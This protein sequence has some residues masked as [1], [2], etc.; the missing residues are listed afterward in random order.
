MWGGIC[1]RAGLCKDWEGLGWEGLGWVAV[2]SF[3]VARA[4]RRGAGRAAR[5]QVA[6][7]AGGSQPSWTGTVIASTAQLST[8]ARGSVHGFSSCMPRVAS[9]HLRL[10]VSVKQAGLPEEPAHGGRVLD[11]PGHPCSLERSV[12]REQPVAAVVS[13]QATHACW[14]HARSNVHPVAKRCVAATFPPGPPSPPHLLG[15]TRL[16]GWM[17][18]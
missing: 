7:W 2:G 9:T 1:R 6:G 18:R 15:S 5:R 13:D 4:R 12:E 8:T 16:W 14:H 11:H 17:G 3:G 10:V